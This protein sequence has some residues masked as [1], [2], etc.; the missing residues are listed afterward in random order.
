MGTFNH[1]LVK[2]VKGLRK[3]RRGGEEGGLINWKSLLLFYLGGGLQII[4]NFSFALKILA[5]LLMERF[6]GR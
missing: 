4:F 1:Q 3:N 5:K 2:L 6:L